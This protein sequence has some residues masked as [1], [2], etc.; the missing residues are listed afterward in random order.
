[1]HQTDKALSYIGICKKSGRIVTGTEMT[2]E[3]IR[4]AKIKLA[5]Y[6]SDASE[7]TEKRLT[8]CCKHYGV[9]YVKGGF[10][11]AKLGKAV[12]SFGTVAAVGITD[13]GLAK[14]IT[15]SI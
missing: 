5:V 10:D 15:D 9:P 12:G 2:C 13:E 8:N 14:A 4:S 7:N 6:S 11:S 3:A 1:M